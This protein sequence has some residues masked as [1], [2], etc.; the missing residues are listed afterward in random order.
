MHYKALTFKAAS[1]GLQANEFA[2]Y[3]STFG[4]VD[5]DGDIVQAGAFARHLDFFKAEGAICWQHSMRTPIGRVL[6]AHEDEKG[7]FLKARISETEQGKD[8]LTL[9]RDGVIR[10]LSIGYEVKGFEILSEASA[11]ELLGERYDD[12]RKMLPAWMEGFRL[13]KEIKVWETSLVTFPA[14]E[15]AAITAVKHAGRTPETERELE[16][17]LRDAGFSRKQATALVADGWKA[18]QRDA[19]DGQAL[20]ELAASLKSLHASMAS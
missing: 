10:K 18:L 4:F 14:N 19:G 6:D 8:A 2:G 16:G 9:L 17:L 20:A 1:E 15:H 3:A 13:L 11:R 12:A 7:L 5:S